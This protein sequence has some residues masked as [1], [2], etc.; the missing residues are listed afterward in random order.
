MDPIALK[1]N[2]ELNA[3][4]H[5]TYKLDDKVIKMDIFIREIHDEIRIYSRSA[6]NVL[7]CITVYIF[8]EH[9][10]SLKYKG[11]GWYVEQQSYGFLWA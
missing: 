1:L 3:H 6:A 11:V 4:K 8:C 10:G 9:L 5:L 7:I 2:A